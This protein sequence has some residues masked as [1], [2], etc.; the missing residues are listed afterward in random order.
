MAPFLSWLAG[1]KAWHF[2][3]RESKG[4]ASIEPFITI[5]PNLLNRETTVTIN[6]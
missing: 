3:T 6:M 1:F 5:N 4:E 2:N